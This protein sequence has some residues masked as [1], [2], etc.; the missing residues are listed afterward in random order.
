MPVKCI[1]ATLY[2]ANVWPFSAAYLKYSYAYEKL[3]STFSSESF[4]FGM[5][6]SPD[7]YNAPKLYFALMLP[8]LA[9][10]FKLEN[11]FWLSFLILPNKLIFP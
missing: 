1:I 3:N 7:K 4:L 11:A 8:Y 9:A 5:I 6:V 2:A 10:F